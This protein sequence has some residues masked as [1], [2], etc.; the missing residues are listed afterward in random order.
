[1]SREYPR[2]TCCCCGGGC[3]EEDPAQDRGY[4]T[5]DRC[6]EWSWQRLRK[7]LLRL[8][9]K[10]RAALLPHNRDRFDRMT[11]PQRLAVTTK[12]IEDGMVSWT[13]ESRLR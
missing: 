12:A 9:R 13:I 7:D 3:F 2:F 8:A 6:A 4:G 1:M 5:C 10:I 11:E